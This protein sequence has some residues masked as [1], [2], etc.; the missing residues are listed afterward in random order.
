M[1]HSATL[2]AVA[3]TSVQPGNASWGYEP[4]PA[5]GSNYLTPL[6]K[7]RTKQLT[8]HK[9]LVARAWLDA[10]MGHI[11]RRF[12][13]TSDDNAPL[14][15]PQTEIGDGVGSSAP[16]ANSQPLQAYASV[17]D[18]CR[19]LDEVVNFLWTTATRQYFPF[20]RPLILCT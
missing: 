18:F 17:E 11:H 19:D 2:A 3:S 8:A 1:V 9:E 13:R 4:P 6:P 14:A 10:R 16:T 12:M 20:H 15:A 5:R 7:P